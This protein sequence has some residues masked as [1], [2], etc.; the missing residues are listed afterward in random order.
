M[1]RLIL[2]ALVAVAATAGLYAYSL[3]RQDVRVLLACMDV[4][5]SAW[6]R[7]ACKRGV[8]WF[9][10]TEAELASLSREAWPKYVILRKEASD[11]PALLA[12]FLARGLDVNAVDAAPEL[13]SS[14]RWS[15]VHI[16]AS[17]LDAAALELLLANGAQP[18]LRDNR[19]KTALDHVLERQRQFPGH[20]YEAVIRVLSRGNA[21]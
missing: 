12:H 4:E 9:H 7:W 13:M 1:K 15:A 11:K 6:A 18:D 16:A 17:E 3:K 10:P 2:A 21:R 19:G 5:D 8:Y 14:S 20:D